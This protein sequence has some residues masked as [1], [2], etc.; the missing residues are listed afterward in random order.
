MNIPESSEKTIYE[1]LTVKIIYEV[2]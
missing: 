2:M 1:V